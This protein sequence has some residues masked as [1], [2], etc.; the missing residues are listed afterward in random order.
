VRRHHDLDVFAGDANDNILHG[1]GCRGVEACGRLVEEE[2]LRC[3]GKRAREGEALLFAARQ[4]PRGPVR[5]ARKANLSEQV[6]HRGGIGRPSRRR[7]REDDVGSCASPQHHWLLKHDGAACCARSRTFAKADAASAGRNEAHAKLEKG[8]LAR[9]VGS[10]QQGWGAAT[11]LEA[12]VLKDVDRS[13][14]H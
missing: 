6:R 1:L 11:D 3:T 7:E 13:G 12:D 10:E 4:L 5:Q 14:A 2:H 8:R 9:A